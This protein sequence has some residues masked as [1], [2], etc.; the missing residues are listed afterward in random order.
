MSGE[1]SLLFNIYLV[2]RER[3]REQEHKQGRGRERRR[4]RIQS[5]LHTDSRAQGGSSNPE[6]ERSCLELKLDAL[7]T[8]P[9]RRPCRDICNW[10]ITAPSERVFLFQGKKQRG[11]LSRLPEC[12]QHRITLLDFLKK[13][14][15]IT[16]SYNSFP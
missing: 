16:Y 9:P 4:Q 14:L 7:L 8:E 3:K 6:T 5:G 10:A 11:L 12:L 15:Q 1:V 2:L 13:K